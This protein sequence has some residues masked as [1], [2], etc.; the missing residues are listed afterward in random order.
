MS[1]T[2]TKNKNKSILDVKRS[3]A[4]IGC[5]MFVIYFTC[6]SHILFL[7]HNMNFIINLNVCVSTKTRKKGEKISVCFL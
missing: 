2:T 5:M 7:I 6:K 3:D 4:L 1:R